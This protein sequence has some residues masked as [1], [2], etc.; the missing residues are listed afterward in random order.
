MLVQ[1]MW[2]P[3]QMRVSEQNAPVSTAKSAAHLNLPC[4]LLWKSL[5]N[6][7]IIQSSCAG[8]PRIKTHIIYRHEACGFAE[9]MHLQKAINDDMR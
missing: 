9:A 1:H 6:A 8:S 7:C 4:L 2:L 5:A 3:T